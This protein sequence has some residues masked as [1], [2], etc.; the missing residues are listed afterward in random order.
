[1]TPSA[2]E[3]AAGHAANVKREAASAAK[4]GVSSLVATVTD[5]AFYQLVLLATTAS[6]EPRGAYAPAAA[7]GALAGAIANFS[8]NRYWAFRSKDKRLL[9][10]A[11]QYAVGSLM[12]LLVLEAVLW[13]IVGRLGFDA[14]AAWLP[15]KLFVWAVFSYPYQRIV[16]FTRAPR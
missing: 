4:A 8:L 6:G 7:A 1:M 3:P 5:G 16:V 12:T 2:D 15:A 10:Q 14:R 13:V 11:A 9:K